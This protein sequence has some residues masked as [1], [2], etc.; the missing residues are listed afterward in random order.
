MSYRM[1]HKTELENGC[2]KTVLFRPYSVD[3]VAENLGGD[4]KKPFLYE[5]N[6]N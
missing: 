3:W 2:A 4:P 6:N 1:Y 5:K